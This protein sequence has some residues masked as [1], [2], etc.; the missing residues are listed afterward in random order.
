VTITPVAPPGVATVPFATRLAGFG[1]RAALLTGD[2]VLSYRALAD[3]VAA[4]AR[5]LGA[6]RRLVMVAGGNA[7]DPI[8]AY[9]AAL[10]AGHP[11]LLVAEEHLETLTAAYDPDVVVTGDRLDERR[12]GT[13][14]ELHPDLAVLLSTSGSTGSPK[15]VRLSHDNVQSNAEA[16][17][18]YL[19]IRD[20]DR[21]ATTLP[22]HYCYGLSVLNSHLLTG[23]GLIVTDL[24]VVD[25]CFWDLF[26]TQH[27]TS[28]AG[29]P[30]TFDLLDRVGFAR[31]RLPSLRYVTQA[32]G[33]LDPERV[34]RYAELGR[35]SG[36]DL[37]VMYGQT[38]AT[39]RMAYLPPHLA[40]TH[41]DAIGIPIPGGSF[42]L[43]PLEEGTDPSVGELVFSGPNVMLG[44][45]ERPADLALGR[46][47]DVLRTGDLARRTPDGVY[48]VVGRRSRFVK[49][50]GLRIDLDQAESVLDENGVRARCVSGGEELVVAIEDDLDTEQVRRL[51]HERLGLPAWSIRVCRLPALPRTANGKPDYQ[52]IRRLVDQVA[53]PR[54]DPA[55]TTDLRALYAELLNRDDVGDDSTFV[56]LDGDSLSY[57]E[58]S[59]RLEEALGHLPAN[60][61]VTPVGELQRRSRPVRRR[62]RQVETN[63]ALRAL[64]IVLIVGSHAN[65]FMVMG[66]AHVLLAVAGFNLA[67]FQLASTG[68]AERTRHL[69]TSIARIA[70]PSMVWIGLAAAISDRYDVTNA[71]LLNS[72][73]GPEQWTTNWHYWFIEALVYI[74]LGVTLLL[75]VPAVHRLERAAPFWLPMGLCALALLARYDV[76]EV[77]G[78]DRIHTV[79]LVCWL[80]F[81]GWAT[82]RAGAVWQRLLVSA[83]AVVAV[84]GFFGDPLREAVVIAGLLLLVWTATVRVPA[85][86]ARLTSVLAAA[87]LYIY[88][89]HWQVYPY[90]E[91]SYPALALLSSLALGL[92]YWKLVSLVAA[93]WSRRGWALRAPQPA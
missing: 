31:M 87:S 18:E 11:V 55:A 70:L 4:L 67:R 51:A 85:P 69:A 74:L 44:Y 48:Q 80:F 3:R 19:A 83:V 79:Q 64:A 91:D 6:E 27:G 1:E 13:A 46:T 20:A 23:A 52:A 9:L 36:W 30:Y 54:P 34:R 57:V 75:A 10:S 93:G 71:L 86:V 60:W 68:R 39:A 32:G 38:E 58:M 81:L 56:S 47:V 16:I 63:V 62:W 37:F 88:L 35:R 29:V 22:M 33:R 26:K 14:H 17:A 76:V 42:T 28:F 2:G 65:L 45:A 49:L 78:S 90:L 77:A 61:H 66:G 59:V 89:T 72:V 24:S 15:L 50:F 82:A 40:G 43:E 53:A 7:I 21:A 92:A 84:A 12:R 8:V 41:P 25:A 5:R 73:L